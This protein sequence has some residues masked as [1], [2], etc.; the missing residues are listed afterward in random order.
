MNYSEFLRSQIRTRAE[1]WAKK[2]NLPHYFS[3]GDHPTVLFDED[4]NANLHGNFHPESWRAMISN[5]LW[6]ER[7]KKPHPQK[8]ALPEEKRDNAKE[9]DSSNSSDAL[10]MNIFC[11]PGSLSILSKLMG[12]NN[13]VEIPEFGFKAKL[14]LDV[15]SSDLTEIDMRWDGVLVESKLTEQDFTQKQKATVFSYQALLNVFDVDL[16]PS[17]ENEF[18]GY[19][20]IRNVLAASQHNCSLIILLDQRRPDLLKEWW[21]VHTAIKIPTLRQKCSY[22][23]WQQLATECPPKL[24]EFLDEKYGL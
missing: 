1:R 17:N 4:S 19:Q 18:L 13:P 16:L 20:L 24:Q 5:P 2:H 6:R 10:L 12:C 8:N 7:L 9:L 11:F 23:L 3:L 21:G 22:R 15:G 14:N